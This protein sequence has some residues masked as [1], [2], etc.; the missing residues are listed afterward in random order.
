MMAHLKKLQEIADP[1]TAIGPSARP[2]R[3]QR[4]Y[5]ANTL[6]DKV[7]MCRRQSRCVN[8]ADDPGAD[9]QG[10]KGR[11]EV[12]GNSTRAPPEGV[13][14][15]WCQR[16]SRTVPRLAPAS[17]Y[18]GSSHAGAVVLVDRGKCSFGVKQAVAAERGA[19]ALIV[20]NNE[21]GDEMGA[22]LVRRPT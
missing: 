1:M 6:R 21:D 12:T 4:D 17:D 2:G 20:A 11:G 22:T 8:D 18:D 15:R 9:R 13:S 14:A 10:R 3:R 19:V 16:G 7:S 5:V